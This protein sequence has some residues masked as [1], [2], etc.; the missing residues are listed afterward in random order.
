MVGVLPKE[1]KQEKINCTM[2]GTGGE[3]ARSQ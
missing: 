3:T 1:V 2:P